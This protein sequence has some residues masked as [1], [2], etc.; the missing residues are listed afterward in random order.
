MNDVNALIKPAGFIKYLIENPSFNNYF[1]A[2]ENLSKRF[3]LRYIKIAKTAGIRE[4]QILEITLLSKQHKKL[5][6]S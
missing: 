3:M 5:A 4:K 1:D 2:F 6:G